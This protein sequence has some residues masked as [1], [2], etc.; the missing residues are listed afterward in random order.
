MS[1]QGKRQARLEKKAPTD[2]QFI[3]WKGKP[4]S[5]EQKAEALRREPNRRI[6]WHSLLEEETA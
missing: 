6:F 5:S 2:Q 1:N 4:W 3:E